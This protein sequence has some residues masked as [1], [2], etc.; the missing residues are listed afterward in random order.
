MAIRSWVN[1]VQGAW[2]IALSGILQRPIRSCLTILTASIGIA[3]VVASMAILKGGRYRIR[4]DLS[5]LGLNIVVI[6]NMIPDLGPVL[7]SKLLK[8]SHVEDV[9]SKAPEGI[10]VIAPAVF[11]RYSASFPPSPRWRTTTVIGCTEDFGKALNLRLKGG[12]FLQRN[13]VLH[14]QPVC[15]MDMAVVLDLFDGSN[16]IG[17]E[18]EIVRGKSSLRLKVV[19][20]LED[21]YRLRRPRG[22]LDTMAMSR[23]LF[24]SRLEFKN[25]YVPMDLIWKNED[26]I[27]TILVK[28]RSTDSVDEVMARLETLFPPEDKYIAM[29]SQK[30]WILETLRSVYDFTAY[31]NVIWIIMMG[32]AAIMI[33]TIRLLS[34]R[35]RYKE[36]AIRRT[37]GAT[38]GAIGLQFSLEGILLCCTGGLLGMGLGVLFAKVLEVT[39]LR[40]RVSFSISAILLAAL[41]SVVVG[42]ASGI[43][44]ARKAALLE[45]VDVLRMG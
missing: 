33:M 43:L 21:P 6:Q 16:A 27:S 38:K 15:V 4:E 20:V 32:V 24:A 19:G 44:P 11:R 41:L 28:T 29:W 1:A 7:Q 34:V 35:E 14:K 10:D 31:S 13:E 42:L 39:V 40:W 26:N 30:E 12:H 5:K 18:I 45:P 36:I 9:R 8:L 17:R 25:I 3:S 37:E 2:R 23:S 22:Q